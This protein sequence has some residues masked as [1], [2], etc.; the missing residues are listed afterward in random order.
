LTTGSELSS[1]EHAHEDLKKG[2]WVADMEE[3]RVDLEFGAEPNPDL[4]MGFFGFSSLE[5][6]AGCHFLR[7][8]SEMSFE[9]TGCERWRGCQ[10]FVCG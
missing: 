3:A 6:N 2:D 8:S 1:P 5:G 4:P 10:G 9:I 7:Q